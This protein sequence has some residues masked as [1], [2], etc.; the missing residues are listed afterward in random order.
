MKR[1]ETIDGETLMSQPL[2]PLNF[3]V[4]TLISQGLHVLAGSPKVGK[5]WLALWLAVTVAKGEPVW[6]LPVKQ[7]TTLYLCLEDS[8][9]RIQN[10]LFD[11]TEDAPP[12]VHFC[13]ESHILG[14]GLEE[15]LRLFL[16]EHPDTSLV[17]ID[18]LQMIR[19]AGCDNTYAN[20]YRDLSALKK[21]ADAHGIAILLIHHLR[22]EK[23]DD[24]F[25]RISGTTA[26]SGAVDASFTLVE[27]QRGSGRASLS[28][29]GRDI[30]RD[31]IHSH[32]I[33]NAVCHE[34]GKMLRQV[35]KTLD[36]LRE[37]S[38]ELCRAHGLSVL[39]SQESKGDGMTSREY[40]SAAK[41]ESWKFQTM[42]AIDRCMRW[43]GS[44]EE[45][46]RA[47]EHLG[48]GVRWEPRRQNITYTHPNGKKVRDRRLHD[49][50][51]WKE[52]MEREFELRQEIIARGIET[53][54]LAAQ[55]AAGADRDTSDS[56][57]VDRTAGNA[58]CPVSPDGNAVRL[59]QEP[60]SQPARLS[61]ERTDTGSA[62]RGSDPASAGAGAAETGTGWEEERAA[63]FNSMAE[64]QSV[65]PVT[66]L[67]VFAADLGRIVGAVVELGSTL[68]RNQSD[69]YIA[70]PHSDRKALR[71]EREKKI[72]MGHRPD[73]REEEQGPNLA[74]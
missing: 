15:Q 13:T 17:I 9:L 60:E 46:V 74:L 25:N 61:A 43:A 55:C 34:T 1:L 31:H 52:M 5:S 29:I 70:R 69:P 10:R 32:F 54:Q 11:V 40:R 38:D 36:R 50:K 71:R 30:D 41:G 66:G 19:N 20:D 59:A 62:G 23:A 42:N 27:E 72:A 73:D 24:V 7:G 26:I 49:E 68:E 67:A 2:Q 48:Y 8:Q 16:A 56:G 64:H 44:R 6:G 14:D 28:C 33:V 65:P 57:G 18:T 12:N 21:L 35:P 45:F 58:Q 53:A 51:Y 22:K 47:M 4:D 37:I 3:V 39:P 63:F